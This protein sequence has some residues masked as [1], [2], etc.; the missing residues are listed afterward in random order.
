MNILVAHMSLPFPLKNSTCLQSGLRQ[1]LAVLL[2]GQHRQAMGLIP[3]HREV[4][5][6]SLHR[7]P[8][9]VLNLLPSVL[10][11]RRLQRT[12]TLRGPECQDWADFLTES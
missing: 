8:A 7:R 2:H 5:L 1:M 3:Y 11:I 12:S 4:V 6:L 9:A 10:L